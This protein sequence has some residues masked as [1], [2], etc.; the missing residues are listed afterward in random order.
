MGERSARGGRRRSEGGSG[1]QGSPEVDWDRLRGLTLDCAG[2]SGAQPERGGE[3]FPAEK[4][5]EAM[6]CW[7]AA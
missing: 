6:D 3:I 1:E 7:R 4:E 2:Q 5:W